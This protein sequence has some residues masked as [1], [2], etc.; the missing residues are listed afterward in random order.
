MVSLK[1]RIDEYAPVNIPARA[2]IPGQ[3]SVYLMLRNEEQLG[4]IRP[5]GIAAAGGPG[6]SLV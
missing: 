2:F 1:E 4:S 6:T 5:V 3:R